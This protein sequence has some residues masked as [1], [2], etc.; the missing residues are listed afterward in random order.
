MRGIG[1]SVKI[2]QFAENGARAGSGISGQRKRVDL[3][4]EGVVEVVGGDK[5]GL[6]GGGD[7]RGSGWGDG[8]SGKQA[9][10][11]AIA[12]LPELESHAER[13]NEED[14]EQ[15]LLIARTTAARSAAG[16]S[17]RHL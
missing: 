17:Q 4:D 14:D 12:K 3:R 6:F 10:V 9:L 15:D 16:A 7:H 1:R 13:G 8:L 5:G 2:E 11:G